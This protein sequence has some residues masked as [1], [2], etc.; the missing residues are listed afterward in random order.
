MQK[1]TYNAFMNSSIIDKTNLFQSEEQLSLLESS[2]WEEL[3]RGVWDAGIMSF[4]NLIHP[5]LHLGYM[6]YYIFFLFP[7]KILKQCFSPVFHRILVFKKVMMGFFH[8]RVWFSLHLGNA[9][10]SP[11]KY[12]STLQDVFINDIDPPCMGH[13]APIQAFLG[14]LWPPNFS[15]N[16]NC[17]KGCGLEHTFHSLPLEWNKT[18]STHSLLLTVWISS[19][20]LSWKSTHLKQGIAY[21]FE[22]MSPFN[23]LAPM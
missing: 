8:K 19:T 6:H 13:T 11:V 5:A 23:V 15:H 10:K 16:R 2:D 20:T 7:L 3:Y 17:M 1:S 21:F 22:C 9:E 14:F 4:L 18:L 12:I